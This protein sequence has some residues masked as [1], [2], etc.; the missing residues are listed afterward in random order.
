[1]QLS[2]KLGYELRVSGE[3]QLYPAV[4]TDACI[5]ISQR[6]LTNVFSFY[7]HNDILLHI[8]DLVTD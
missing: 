2:G 1:M 5:L 3:A 7:G 6:A 4:L 8:I